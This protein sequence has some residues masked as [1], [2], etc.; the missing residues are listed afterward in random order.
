MLLAVLEIDVAFF[1]VEVAVKIVR[2][3][4]TIFPRVS[5]YKNTLPALTLGYGKVPKIDSLEIYVKR[6]F[7]YLTLHETALVW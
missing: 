2:L 5:S 6:G 1:R 7:T 3:A 4:R